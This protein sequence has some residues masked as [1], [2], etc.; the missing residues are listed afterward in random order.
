MESNSIVG[1]LAAMRNRHA[2]GTTASYEWRR[3]QLVTLK[4]VLY[5]H[6]DDIYAALYSD[7]KKNK[8]ECWI[9]ELGFTIAEINFALKNLR[10]W[11]APKNVGTNL[12]NFPGKS[13]ILSEPLGVVLIISP[14]NYPLQLLLAP[15][16]GALAAGNSA[17]LKPSEFAPATAALLQKIIGDTFDE[18]Y[19][20]LVQGNGAEVIPAMMNAFRFD[21]VFYTGSTATGTLIY[22]M[23]AKNL[24]PVTLELGG[25]SPCIIESDA[26]IK[27]AAK[28]I[29]LVKFSNAG[30]MCV[31]PDYLLI[32][33]S[34]KGVFIKEQVKRIE[35]YYVADN[36]HYGKLI[37]AK[38]FDRLVAFLQQGTII[39][40]G[41]INT[42]DHSISP[43]LVE[44]ITP[45][46]ALMKE[47][48]FGPLL[49]VLT[50]QHD[51]EVYEMISQ[52][53]NPLALYV[54]TESKAKAKKWTTTIPFGGGCINNASLHLT[55][56]HLPFGGRGNS[57]MGV[58][59]GH[60]SFDTFSHKKGILK[61]PTWFDPSVKY[62]PFKGRLP[63]LKRL[64]K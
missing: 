64:I 13:Y 61:T 21:H 26:D 18:F 45:G 6:E 4:E 44:N 1:H 7:L 16:V 34:I 24:T 55:N 10:K 57:G 14:W 38:A 33:E 37:N 29:A 41:K 54:F 32:H 60:F 23:A 27:V 15:L 19:I 52:N 56:H 30:Q 62:P 25:K 22:E 11:M 63:L 20:K 42:G 3:Q 17:V 12:L 46:A 58:Y 47:E 43:A 36:Y 50:W 49:P 2:S 8:E 28:R 31:A 9:T 39:Y 59:H 53:S 35:E 51:D 40:G 5:K 48:I